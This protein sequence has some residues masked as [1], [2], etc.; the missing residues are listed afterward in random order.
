MVKQFKNDFLWGASSSA[1][2]IEGAW[3]EDGK[4]LTVADYNSL[5]SQLYKQIRKSPAILPS[6]QRGHCVNERIRLKTYRFSLSWAR[7]IPTGDG[8]INQAGIDFYNAVIDTLLENDILP[9]VTLYHFDLP[10][11]LVEKYNGWAD[12][13]CVSAFQRYAQVCYQAFGDRVKIGKLRTNK[14]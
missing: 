2:Q 7:I 14:T 3:N 13:R 5:K 9:F 10:F 1:F 12:R 4:G 8:E 6:F 11:A